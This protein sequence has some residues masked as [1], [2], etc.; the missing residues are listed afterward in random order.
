MS[1]EEATATATA[2]ECPARIVVAIDNSIHAEQAFEFYLNRIHR[3]GYEVVFA[4]SAEPPHVGGGMAVAGFGV[5]A[6]PGQYEAL[7]EKRREEVR[8]LQNKF[9]A[10][11]DQNAHVKYRMHAVEYGGNPGEAIVKI[12]EDEK[13][14]MVVMGTRGLGAI[15][16]TILGSV[17]D[18]VVHHAKCPV[19]ICH[20]DGIH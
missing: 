6:T 4:H 10:H 18:Y 2:E 15:R 5:A 19:L 7:L 9:A 12:S 3:P 1:T 17:S 13:A 20:K 11:L 14:T 8:E 16:R